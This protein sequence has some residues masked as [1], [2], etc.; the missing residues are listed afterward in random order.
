MS[1]PV[2]IS[3]VMCEIMEKFK[4]NRRFKKRY[5]K[6]FKQ[7][8]IGANM[9][10]LLA[11]LADDKGRVKIQGTNEKEVARE[12]TKLMEARFDDPAEYAL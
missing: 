8:P 1:E 2:H 4:P 6:L 7:D 12:L 11:E 3:T 9:F 10:L 5:D